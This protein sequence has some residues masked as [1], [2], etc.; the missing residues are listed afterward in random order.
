MLPLLF[1]LGV[2]AIK[3]AVEDNRRRVQDGI[4]NSKPCLVY[5]RASSQPNALRRIHLH[6]MPENTFCQVPWKAVHVGD[7]I[8]VGQARID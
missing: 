5:H 3:D 6:N 4:Q 1:V 7:I 2:T 8:E